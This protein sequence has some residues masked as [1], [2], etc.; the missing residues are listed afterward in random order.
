MTGAYRGG[1]LGFR[2]S[3]VIID[4]GVHL[5]WKSILICINLISEKTSKWKIREEMHV[6]S[7]QGMLRKLM[8][9]DSYCLLPNTLKAIDSEHV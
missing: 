2:I 9:L 5:L 6:P 8:R 3:V 7:G 4:Y 1:F